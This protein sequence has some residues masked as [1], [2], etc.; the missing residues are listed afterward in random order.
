[1]Q[2]FLTCEKTYNFKKE[3]QKTKKINEECSNKFVYFQANLKDH[4][5]KRNT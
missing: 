4:Y 1:M 2:K 3:V 5:T